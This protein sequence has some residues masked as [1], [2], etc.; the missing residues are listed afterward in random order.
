MARILAIGTA[1]LD[2]IYTLERYPQEDAELRALNFRLG[3]GG[4]ATNTLVV[5]SQL[6]HECAFGGVL[7]EGPEAAPI[8]EDLARYRIDL[9]FCRL[10]PG[11]PPISCILIS[12]E[13]GTRTIVH[14]RD[15]PEY[16][17]DEFRRI[18]LTP[19]DWIHFEGRHGG[20]TLR[21]L[22]RVRNLRSGLPC[23]VEVEKPRPGI[24]LVFAEADVLLFS[25]AYV[26]AV[27]VPLPS[28]FLHQMREQ[29]PQADLI[30]TWGEEGAYGL[31]RRGRGYYSPP[32]P[33]SEVM[34]TLGAGDT[35]NA[36]IIDAYLRGLG[37]AETL[38]AACRLAG[39]KCGQV[40]FEGLG[41]GSNVCLE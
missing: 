14:Y 17:Y 23:S 39:K 22:R 38:A 36:G 21:M 15:L 32:Y 6:G 41:A 13:R 29:A 16:S 28:A 9:S 37:L 3:R 34:E 27:G 35:F 31:D 20:E 25:Q 10:V 24:E 30:L 8:L 19:F 18:D 4:N 12:L 7:A 26:R 2:F 11:R 1:T 40:G 5:L 33:P